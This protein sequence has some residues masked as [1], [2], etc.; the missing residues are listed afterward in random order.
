MSDLVHQS[1]PRS[2]VPATPTVARMRWR[3]ALTDLRS[4]LD[5]DDLHIVAL[6]VAVFISDLALLIALFSL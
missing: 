2:G 1:Q 6:L 3:R 5:A 4:R